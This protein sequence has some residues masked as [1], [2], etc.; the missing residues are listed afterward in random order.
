MLPR[1]TGSDC[2]PRTRMLDRIFIAQSA[3]FLQPVPSG[4][5]G[6]RSTERSVIGTRMRSD[7]SGMG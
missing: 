5:A 1:L 4:F 6:R 7:A 2:P 3:S